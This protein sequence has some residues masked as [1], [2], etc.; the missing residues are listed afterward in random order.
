MVPSHMSK[1]IWGTQI[2]LESFLFFFKSPLNSREVRAGSGSGKSQEKGEYQDTLCRTF[3]Q[4]LTGE[5]KERKRNFLLRVTFSLA[6]P[7][8]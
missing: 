2:Y 3:L 4:E 7:I 8:P 1:N 6:F 5:K